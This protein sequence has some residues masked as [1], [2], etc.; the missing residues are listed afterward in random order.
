MSRVQRESALEDQAIVGVGLGRALTVSGHS[1]RQA[2]LE[3]A[4]LASVSIDPVD[5][6]V[7]L[8]GTLVVDDAALRPA[9][10]A[11]AAF[12]SDDAVVDAA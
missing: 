7:L 10:E 2:F 1:E 12:A 11:L 3:A 4:E 5:D 6:A 9:K 8:A